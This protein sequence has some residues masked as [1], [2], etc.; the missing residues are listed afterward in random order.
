MA[1][2]SLGAL[3]KVSLGASASRKQYGASRVP[4]SVPRGLFT[5]MRNPSD[6]NWPSVASYGGVG[7]IDK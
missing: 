4:D 7:M 1:L 5:G 6:T 2:R 3:S